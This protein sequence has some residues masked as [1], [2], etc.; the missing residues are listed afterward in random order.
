MRL[1]LEHLNQ[2]PAAEFVDLLG[3]VWEH[4]PWI[5]AAVATRRPFSSVSELHCAM[6]SEITG[7]DEEALV[8]F[9]NLHPEL[10][11]PVSAMAGMTQES[12]GEQNGL[13][14]GGA[15]ADERSRWTH[16]NSADRER[17]G[18]PFILCAR[19]HDRLSALLRFEERLA[20]DR[21]RE[22]GEA[23]SEIRKISRLRLDDRIA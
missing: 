22:I 19:E 2:A 23:L 6:F 10:A 13:A 7:L 5:A 21:P 4:S 3:P 1:S 11:G 12:Q 15:S 17:F 8:A 14:I 9:L 20:R 16:L 18:F